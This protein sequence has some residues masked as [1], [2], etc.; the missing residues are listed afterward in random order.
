M[1]NIEEMVTSEE[2]TNLARELVRRRWA[3]APRA[4]RQVR[5]R[6][7]VLSKRLRA[8]RQAET[9]LMFMSE[10]YQLCTQQLGWS[11]IEGIESGPRL[12]QNS[13]SAKKSK[14]KQ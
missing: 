1:V 8:M 3:K 4:Q 6:A 7:A 10:I 13:H 5:A 2:A 11:R 12:A 9:A 14:Q